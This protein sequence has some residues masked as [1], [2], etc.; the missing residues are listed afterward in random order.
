MESYD[1]KKREIVKCCRV[2][3]MFMRLLKLFDIIYSKLLKKKKKKKKRNKIARFCK[4]FIYGQN[5]SNTIRVLKELRKEW[6]S[7]V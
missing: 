3:G 1:W 7:A 2:T 6:V 5:R 4:I